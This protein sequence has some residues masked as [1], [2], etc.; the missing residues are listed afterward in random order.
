MEF[1]EAATSLNAGG[2][3]LIVGVMHLRLNGTTLADR[4]GCDVVTGGDPALWTANVGTIC[5]GEVARGRDGMVLMVAV[6]ASAS[7]V[8][9]ATAGICEGICGS[10]SEGG[11]GIKIDWDC[12]G[13]IETGADR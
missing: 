12:C 7:L 9:A 2:E 13:M 6:A 11:C 3:G 4:M 1:G 5:G 8:A 10:G